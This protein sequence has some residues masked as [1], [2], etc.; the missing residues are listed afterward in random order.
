MA[1]DSAATAVAATAKLCTGQNRTLGLFAMQHRLQCDVHVKSV[2]KQ[3]CR[4]DTLAADRLRSQHLPHPVDTGTDTASAA[5]LP[6]VPA[7]LA[8]A[9][10]H[11]EP[12]GSALL[13]FALASPLGCTA[14]P[15][16]LLDCTRGLALLIGC[17]G[18]LV[19]LSLLNSSTLC[20]D[21]WQPVKLYMML[22]VLY[23]AKMS[24][25]VEDLGFCMSPRPQG[26]MSH[27]PLPHGSQG[28]LVQYHSYT[29][30]LF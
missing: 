14:G 13:V 11:E 28:L 25:A 9:C 18:G 15:D 5:I 22:L 16:L 2:T 27:N 8:A 6:A 20:H 19:L 26:A 30:V 23:T 12:V 21:Q 10:S 3:F 29:Q 4:V 17:T 1:A 24:T 7:L